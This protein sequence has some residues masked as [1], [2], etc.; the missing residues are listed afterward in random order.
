MTIEPAVA[1]VTITAE[2]QFSD[3]MQ[4]DAN[5][6]ASISI[7]DDSS[8]NMTVMLQRQLPGQTTWQDIPD[9]SGTFGWTAA[10]QL[11]YTASER[12]LLRIG[13]KTGGYT[14]GTAT[15]RIGKG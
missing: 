10:T 6:V 4:M 7:I 11:S 8:M 9:A 13:C 15:A 14:S 12:Q 5:E 1:S 2:N 3:S